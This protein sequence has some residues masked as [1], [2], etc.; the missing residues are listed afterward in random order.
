MLPELFKSE[1][2]LRILRYVAERENVTVQTVAKTTRVSKPVVS[3]YM[4]L[5]VRNGLCKRTG[6]TMAWIP[7][8]VGSAIKRFL[9]I[10]L[11]DEHLLD[12]SWAESIGMYGSFARGTNNAGSDID[13]W[14]LVSKHS[15]EIEAHVAEL[16][17]TL[18]HSLGYDI[19]ILILTREKLQDLSLKDAPFYEEFMT[20]QVVIR[21]AAI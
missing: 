12:T 8:P 11:L 17:H 14:V 5:L 3:R 21:G 6:R 9:N 10:I 16:R 2:R 1:D 19:H 20:D 7:S 18:S 13:V 4:H 15:D